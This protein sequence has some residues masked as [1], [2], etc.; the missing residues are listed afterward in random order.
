MT[1]LG[2]HELTVTATFLVPHLVDEPFMGS[3]CCVIAADEAIQQELESWPQ[4]LSADVS[5]DTG[6]AVV[7]LNAPSADLNPLIETLESLG[8]PASIKSTHDS[9]RRSRI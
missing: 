5:S 6:E 7:T 1:S 8:F 9:G 4:V 3:G 2:T